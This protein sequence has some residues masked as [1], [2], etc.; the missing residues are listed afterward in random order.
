M[1]SADA[2]PLRTK[3]SSSDRSASVKRTTNTFFIASVRRKK[4][5]IAVLIWRNGVR[6]RGEDCEEKEFADRGW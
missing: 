4:A 3:A 2:F 1:A 6:A 5:D